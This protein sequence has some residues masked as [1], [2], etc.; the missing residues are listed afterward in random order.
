MAGS[1]LSFFFWDNL[2]I[3]VDLDEL[4]EN[5]IELQDQSAQFI[6]VNQ[7]LLLQLRNLRFYV[8]ELFDEKS[9][10]REKEHIQRV[11]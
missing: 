7:T 1:S 3:V 2:E 5:Q 9:R 4:E 8:T 10:S 11:N 6:V